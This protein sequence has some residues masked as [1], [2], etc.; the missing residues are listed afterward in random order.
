MRAYCVVFGGF[1]NLI[2]SSSHSRKHRTKGV[3]FISLPVTVQFSVILYFCI[4]SE[5]FCHKIQS[6]CSLS[7]QLCFF[8]LGNLLFVQRH[9]R[10][11]LTQRA[12][13][14][15]ASASQKEK[16]LLFK[17]REDFIKSSNFFVKILFHS[18]VSSPSNFFDKVTSDA[19]LDCNFQC[20]VCTALR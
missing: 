20:F 2:F 3:H 9:K 16:T 4:P 1:P 14:Q 19:P 18:T 6:Y 5:T 8:K 12:I 15:K 17:S 10:C 13:Q 11:R 7:H